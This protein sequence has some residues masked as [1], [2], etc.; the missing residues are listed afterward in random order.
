MYDKIVEPVILYGISRAGRTGGGK[1]TVLSIGTGTPEKNE[2]GYRNEGNMGGSRVTGS[3]P[4]SSSVQ[5]QN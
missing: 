3:R 2:N 1:K 4:T 5:E